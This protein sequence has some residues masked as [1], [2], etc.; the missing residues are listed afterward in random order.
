M[1][2]AGAIILIVAGFIVSQSRSGQMAVPVFV[3]G[4][5]VGLLIA[6]IFK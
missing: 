2:W 4:I 1:I 3:S 6:G 5:G